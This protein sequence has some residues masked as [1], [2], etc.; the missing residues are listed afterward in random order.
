MHDK[1]IYLYLYIYIY[2]WDHFYWSSDGRVKKITYSTERSL[3]L[4]RIQLFVPILNFGHNF[5]ATRQLSIVLTM[6]YN[7]PRI[8]SNWEWQ[9]HVM[10]VENVKV[11]FE[12]GKIWQTN[13]LRKKNCRSSNLRLSVSTGSIT[14]T[15]SAV[16]T[17]I[18][19]QQL[20]SLLTT[21]HSEW[22]LSSLY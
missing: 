7:P 19:V 20:A 5:P 18:S 3:R 16:S 12:E 13:Y 17:L 8:F 11:N 10:T 14:A 15:F 6:F 21:T 9:Q 4:N 2:I 22:L 1:L